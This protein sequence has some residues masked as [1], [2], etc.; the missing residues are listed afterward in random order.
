MKMSGEYWDSVLAAHKDSAKF[1]LWR[2]PIYEEY[3]R[4]IDQWCR[5][6]RLKHVLKTDLFEEATAAPGLVGFL[7]QKV[8]CLVGIDRSCE[9]IVQAR[10]KLG[11]GDS[12]PTIFVCCDIRHLPFRPDFFD[13]VIS[14][15]TLDHFTAKKHIVHS[16]KEIWSATKTGGIL[17]L[18][19][20]NPL[21]PLILFRNALPYRLLKALRLIPYFMG[22]LVTRQELLRIMKSVGFKVLTSGYISHCPRI[23]VV[24]IENIL[25]KMFKPSFFEDFIKI[26]DRFEA[27][28]ELPT[29]SLTA[30]FIMISATK[31]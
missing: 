19:L 20:D 7:K 6:R 22:L 18:T 15:S 27:L 5:T 1:E 13:L 29:K 28:R 25:V 10:K 17:I 2:L 21:N 16:L 9:C 24:G 14:N 11:Q 12:H 8:E 4:L 31:N 23:A 26:M 3:E 30:Q